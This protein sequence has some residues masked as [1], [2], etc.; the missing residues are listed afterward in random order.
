MSPIEVGLPS[1]RH[2]HFNKIS[3]DMLR[4]CK[5]DFL[6]ERRDDLNDK[7]VS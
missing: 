7:L 2:L 6:D 4:R 3:N 1:P 5:L